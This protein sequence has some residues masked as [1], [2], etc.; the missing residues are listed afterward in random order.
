MRRCPTTN[1]HL[2]DVDK[3]SPMAPISALAL[4]LCAQTPDVAPSPAVD[5]PP[6]DAVAEPSAEEKTAAP[7]A[8][9]AP[10]VTTG[11]DDLD[12]GDH[13][14]DDGDYY[15]AV[16]EYRRY[17]WRTKGRGEYAPRVAMAIGEAYL[18]GAQYESAA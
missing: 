8:E 15:R 14:F 6:A 1:R 12:F 11:E 7:V 17:L 13:L 16:T 5:K 4:L 2:A 9:P 3:K 18:R 10:E